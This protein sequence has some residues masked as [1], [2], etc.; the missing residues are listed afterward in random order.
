MFGYLTWCAPLQLLSGLTIT[1]YRRGYYHAASE[2][3]Q[4][5][6]LQRAC[7]YER[8]FRGSASRTQC[9]HRILSRGLVGVRRNGAADE[10]GRYPVSLLIFKPQTVSCVLESKR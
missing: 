5:G 9:L 10:R 6:C 1:I 7:C 4:A 3:F 8:H 2:G